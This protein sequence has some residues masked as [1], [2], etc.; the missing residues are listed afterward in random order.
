MVYSQE[1]WHAEGGMNSAGELPP[2][3]SDLDIMENSQEA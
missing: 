3:I 1:E 2:D